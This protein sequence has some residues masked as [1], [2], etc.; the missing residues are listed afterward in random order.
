MIQTNKHYHTFCNV[1]MI[2]YTLQVSG[3]VTYN[4]HRIDEFVP[5]RTSA[6]ISQHDLHIPEL[7]VRETLAFSARCQGV[8]ARF[9]MTLEINRK[10][11]HSFFCCFQTQFSFHFLTI[12]LDMLSELLRREKEAHIIPDADID[13]FMKTRIILLTYT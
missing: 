5:E 1:V 10:P 3:R 9:G 11:M 12:L 13:A 7:T 4:G 8:G 2:I 6:Y